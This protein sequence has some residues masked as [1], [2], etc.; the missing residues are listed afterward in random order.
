MLDKMDSGQV[1]N[2]IH[3]GLLGGYKKGSRA[4]E[5][6][7]FRRTTLS[8]ALDKDF[9]AA[10]TY[11]MEEFAPIISPDV[12]VFRGPEHEGAGIFSVLV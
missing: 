4:Q 9:G 7:L 1:A 12:Y 10:V 5:E 8:S 11:P 2:R 3:G 6:D